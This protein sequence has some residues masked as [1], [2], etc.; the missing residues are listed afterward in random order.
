MV[1]ARHRRCPAR[2]RQ[3]AIRRVCLPLRNALA[4]QKTRRSDRTIHRAALPPGE[5]TIRDAEARPR[6]AGGCTR[7]GRRTPAVARH[8]DARDAARDPARPAFGEPALRCSV[9]KRRIRRFPHVRTRVEPGPAACEQCV[10]VLP[11]TPDE[12]ERERGPFD[13]PNRDS[14]RVHFVD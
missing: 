7:R 5:R 3:S 9:G 2:A 8:T 6:P 10:E 4:A 13:A 1:A 11:A 12:A 14:P